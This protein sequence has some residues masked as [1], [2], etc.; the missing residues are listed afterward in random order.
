MLKTNQPAPTNIA[1]LDEQGQSISLSDTLGKYVVLYFYPRDNT[2][3][4]TKEACSFRDANQELEKLG[5]RV[6]GVSKDSVASHQ[7]FKQKHQLNFELWSDPDHELMEAFGAWG[8]KSTFGK[9]YMG[10]IRSTFV[11][12]PQGKIIKVWSA[13]K[14]IGHAEQVLKFLKP[15]IE[16]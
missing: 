1:V 3:G 10:V 2:P 6:I 14:P 5:A 11:I 4:C 7:G 16:K 8:E 9:K 13:V 12:D 15:I